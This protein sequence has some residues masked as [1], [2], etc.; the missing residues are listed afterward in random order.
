M[1]TMGNYRILEA[2]SDDQLR[3]IAPSIFAEEPEPGVSDRYGF[4][5]TSEVVAAMR[6][7]GLVPTYAAQCR[8]K[9][10]GNEL[11]TKHMIRFTR[12]SDLEKFANV[13][14]VVD[15]N[16]HHFF[17]DTPEI[18]Q[19]SLVNAHDRTS[20]Y[21]LDAAI[22][23]LACSNGLM[24]AG[25]SFDSI[26]VRHGKQIVNEVL[27]GTYR[28]AEQMPRVFER[29]DEMK[30]IELNTSTQLAFAEV[31]A[32]VRWP[33]GS[34]PV[35]PSKLLTRRRIEDQKP[36]LWSTYNVVQEN[37]MRGGLHGRATTGR[38]LTTRAIESV[39]EDVKLNRA[40]WLTA[41][42]MRDAARH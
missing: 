33:D 14:R 27:E 9:E 39:N 32:A 5:P 8:V 4:I 2:L 36:D 25:A 41:D 20:T 21:Q 1:N 22:W 16:A 40:L 15:G 7:E 28:I 3:K 10:K 26:H 31:A 17:K 11:F 42:A 34:M 38:R 19:V 35:E 12:I 24:V 13:P 23:R 18:A 30:Q 37:L 29:V 6:K